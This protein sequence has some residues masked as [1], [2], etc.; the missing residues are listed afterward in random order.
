MSNKPAVGRLES[1][2]KGNVLVV[3]LNIHSDL[4]KYALMKFRGGTVPM[5]IVFD[6]NG[7]E[8]WRR[9]GTVPSLDTILSLNLHSQK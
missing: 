7:N 5:F 8:V 4:G 2:L 9:S 1:N 3:K 6:E